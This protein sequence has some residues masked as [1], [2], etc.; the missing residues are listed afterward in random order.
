MSIKD[1][2]YYN[3]AAIPTTPPH[4]IPDLSP[5]EDGTIWSDLAGEK[6]FLRRHNERSSFNNYAII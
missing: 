2:K 1:W 4:E 5:I 6:I 3:H